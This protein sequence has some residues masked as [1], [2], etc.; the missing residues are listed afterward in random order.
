VI[1]EMLPEIDDSWLPDREGN[2]YTCEL[3]LTALD[4]APMAAWY[5]DGTV[6]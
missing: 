5:E 6:K 1:T 2:V 3:R 4:L